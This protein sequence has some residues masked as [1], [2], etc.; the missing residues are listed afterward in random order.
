MTVQDIFNL[1][2][3]GRTDEAW[4]AIQ[5]MFAVHKGKHTTLAYFWTAGDK[6]KQAAEAKDGEAARKLLF[7]MV[8][9]Y[10]YIEDQDLQAN[11]AVI[12]AAL[13]V[14]DLIEQFNLAYFMPYFDRLKDDDW[15]AVKVNDHWVPALGERIISHLFRGIEERKDPKYVETVKPMLEKALHLHP[16]DKNNQR[17]MARLYLLEGNTQ[18]AEKVLRRIIEKQ[19]DAASCHDLSQ[20]TA[21]PAERI[22]LVCQAIL[23]QPQE[24]FRSKMRVELASLLREKRPANALF[25]LRKSRQ[26]REAMGNHVPEFAQDMERQLGNITPATNQEQNDF[27][28]RAIRYLKNKQ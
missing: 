28:L 9:A 10:P 18:Q 3:E 5:P 13:R 17:F 4:E 2:K 14:D 27:Y 15:K 11:C 20:L 1:R 12:K 7:A 26:T 6:L 19:K 24:K 16:N 22:A 21:D 23:W 25:E 8:T